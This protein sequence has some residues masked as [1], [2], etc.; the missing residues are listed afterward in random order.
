ME[1]DTSDPINQKSYN[2]LCRIFCALWE[3]IFPL[4]SFGQSVISYFSFRNKYQPIDFAHLQTL[5]SCF[6]RPVNSLGLI[7]LQLGQHDSWMACSK[8]Q[9]SEFIGLNRHGKCRSDGSHH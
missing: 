9:T 2:L 6:C 1:L 3:F 4:S 5:Y 8:F 7:F